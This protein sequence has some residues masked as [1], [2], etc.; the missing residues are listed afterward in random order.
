MVKD[1]LNHSVA[2]GSGIGVT[3]IFSELRVIDILG[4][5]VPDTCPAP[6]FHIFM[7]R[8]R[9][10]S[11]CVIGPERKCIARAFSHY[12]LSKFFIF[13][14]GWID[15]DKRYKSAEARRFV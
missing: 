7:C 8:P 15:L 2:I 11:V 10:T 12:K 9:N 5:E 1:K 14:I 6:P 4:V 13:K 3:P